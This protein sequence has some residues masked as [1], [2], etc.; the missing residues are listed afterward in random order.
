VGERARRRIGRLRGQQ[1][2]EEEEAEPRVGIQVHVFSG[3]AS[4]QAASTLGGATYASRPVYRRVH[5]Y[6]GSSGQGDDG[7]DDNDRLEELG[8]NDV[9]TA[10]F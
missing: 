5:H 10:F 3:V 7:D 2:E 8:R 1:D 6:S 4:Q 9:R